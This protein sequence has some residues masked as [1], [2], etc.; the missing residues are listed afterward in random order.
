[1]SS[2]IKCFKLSERNCGEHCC[3]VMVPVSKTG[4][5]VGREGILFSNDGINKYIDDPRKKLFPYSEVPT[6]LEKKI[7]SEPQLYSN[8]IFDYDNLYTVLESDSC[9]N[10]FPFRKS[11]DGILVRDNFYTYANDTAVY[12]MSRDDLLESLKSTDDE[13]RIIILGGKN[14]SDEIIIPKIDEVVES[15]IDGLKSQLDSVYQKFAFSD[16]FDYSLAAYR[17]CSQ[18]DEL[19]EL[20][21]DDLSFDL[22]V[23]GDVYILRIPKDGDGYSIDKVHIG[24]NNKDKYRVCVTNIMSDEKNDSRINYSS[25]GSQKSI[26]KI[27]EMRE[28]VFDE[29]LNPDV[30]K[31]L[32]KKVNI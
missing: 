30:S 15:A 24:I 23:L 5:I 28:P 19:E 31:I 1:M 18:I 17:V 7:F 13:E 21:D 12:S 29:K 9:T 16:E 32:S 14:C 27:K 2:K 6:H 4:V 20:S 25:I 26:D 10:Y 8:Q 3:M 22:A 11:K